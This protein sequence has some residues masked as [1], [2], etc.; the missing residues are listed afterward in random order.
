VL[1]LIYIYL[2]IYRPLEI[3]GWTNLTTMMQILFMGCC[4]SLTLA[5]LFSLSHNFEKSERD[6]VKDFRE[7]GKPV[8]WFKSQVETSCTYGGFIAGALTGGLNFQIEHHLFPM[9]SNDVLHRI[10]PVVQN[11]AETHALPYHG[12]TTWPQLIR[13]HMQL[14][15]NRRRSPT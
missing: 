15:T 1:R 5:T 4:E 9:I 3:A 7:T 11:F 14:L 13:S 10:A 2:V 6:P 8:C 12:Y